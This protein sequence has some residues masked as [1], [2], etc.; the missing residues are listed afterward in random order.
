[1]AAELF[2]LKGLAFIMRALIGLVKELTVF[3]E[4]P[5]VFD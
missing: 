1:M 2:Y 4:L 3:V 5:F